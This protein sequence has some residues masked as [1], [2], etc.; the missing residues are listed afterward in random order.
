MKLRYDCFLTLPDSSVPLNRRS[1][2]RHPHFLK[3][4]FLFLTQRAARIA[5]NKKIMEDMGVQKAVQDFRA[6]ANTTGQRRKV[7]T[8]FQIDV[9]KLP[10]CFLPGVLEHQYNYEHFESAYLCCSARSVVQHQHPFHQ[11][12]S[13]SLADYKHKQGSS[14]S[15]N[16]DMICWN[17]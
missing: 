1:E 15:S 2:K 9:S 17:Y 4:Q 8:K 16:R 12:A 5:R 13:G 7:I 10:A 6:A 14:S 11:L 3:L